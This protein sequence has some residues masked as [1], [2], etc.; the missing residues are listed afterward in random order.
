MRWP[1]VS[2]AAFEMV[3]WHRDR[4]GFDLD[5]AEMRYEQLMAEIL[6]RGLKD[7]KEPAPAEPD[8]KPLPAV[9]ASA[10]G[11]WPEGSAP[12]VQN[13]NYAFGQLLIRPDE[14]DAIALEIRQGEDVEL[15]A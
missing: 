10:L 12:Y 3:I 13:R 11:Q 7:E 8:D 2:R 5:R 15:F 6:R 14:A 9:I 1:F 4:L